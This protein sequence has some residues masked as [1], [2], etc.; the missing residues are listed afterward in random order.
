MKSKFNIESAPAEDNSLRED[1][2]N[3]DSET[4]SKIRKGEVSLDRASQLMDRQAVRQTTQT[5]AFYAQLSHNEESPGPHHTVA[6]D[7][8]K[9]NIHNS[10]NRYT[11]AFSAPINGVYGFIYTLRMFCYNDGVFEFIK[12]DEV[13]GTIQVNVDGGCAGQFTTGSVILALN[14]GDTVYVRT[15]STI[16]PNGRILSDRNGSPY[17]T[18]WLIAPL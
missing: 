2:Q 16:S 15:H 3:R 1:N 7:S 6:F 12:N 4:L 18:G 8:V 13:E 10:Y 17:F 9:T 14:V 5:V 11:G